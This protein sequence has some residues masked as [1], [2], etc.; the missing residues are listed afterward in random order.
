[1][2]FN[3]NNIS[4]NYYSRPFRNNVRAKGMKEQEFIIKKQIVKM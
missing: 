1:M 3:S 2:Y 4:R